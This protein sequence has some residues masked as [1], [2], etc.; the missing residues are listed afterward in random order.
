MSLTPLHNLS[1]EGNV[2]FVF[3]FSLMLLM[4]E[5]LW[6]HR[7]NFRLALISAASKGV[8]GYHGIALNNTETQ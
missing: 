4:R 7:Q 5:S 2:S 6:K 8:R 3:N 1:P